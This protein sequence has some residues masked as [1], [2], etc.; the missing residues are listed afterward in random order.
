M[1]L[2]AWRLEK[3]INYYV[4][5][6]K[7]FPSK[8][9]FRVRL[10]QPSQACPA[11]SPLFSIFQSLLSTHN[12]TFPRDISFGLARYVQSVSPLT[13]N[14]DFLFSR[15]SLTYIP[16]GT[17]VCSCNM[18]KPAEGLREMPA[19]FV[20]EDHTEDHTE[21]HSVVLVFLDYWSLIGE[22]R[23]FL[24]RGV[25]NFFLHNLDN[26]YAASLLAVLGSTSD[27]ASLPHWILRTPP[28][29]YLMN[30]IRY[31]D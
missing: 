7:N 25:A 30:I 18:T 27:P 15:L 9:F 26:M 21:D 12:I 29:P 17:Y 20:V 23:L 4:E 10:V 14:P 19:Y 24:S 16:H 8:P 22:K 6:T 13:E 1:L 31:R 5:A 11:L 3:P 28:P 2:R